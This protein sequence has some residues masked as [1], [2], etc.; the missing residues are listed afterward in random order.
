MPS[1]LAD[2]IRKMVSAGTPPELLAEIVQTIS[3][4]S[5]TQS[6]KADIIRAEKRRAQDRALKKKYRMSPADT[7]PSSILSKLSSLS[8]SEKKK[9]I[10]DKQ[11]SS[12]MVLPFSDWPKDF[13]AQFWTRFPRKV[14]KIAAMKALDKVKARGDVTWAKLIEAVDRYAD[15]L[16]DVPHGAW[17]PAA[18]HPATWLNAG[19]WDD[20]HRE[21]AQNG[22]T[23]NAGFQLGFSG[24]AATIKSKSALHNR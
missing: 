16:T 8:D 4:A 9:G 21:E 1:N 13:H 6:Q 17:R 15:Y 5:P 20:E 10:Q 19:C 2:L 7:K 22:K 11:D 3:E 23:R 14:G 12:S 24:L 18:K